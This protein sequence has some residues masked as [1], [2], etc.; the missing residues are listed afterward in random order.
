M[1]GGFMGVFFFFYPIGHLEGG[2]RRQR[3]NDG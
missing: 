2:K 1:T 3:G